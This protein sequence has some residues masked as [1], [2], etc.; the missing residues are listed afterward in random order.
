MAT[1]KLGTFD[2]KSAFEDVDI[3]TFTGTSTPESDALRTIITK[4]AG[5]NPTIISGLESLLTE[6]VILRSFERAILTLVTAK[7]ERAL[8][9]VEAGLQTTINEVKM[10]NAQNSPYMTRQKTSL[11]LYTLQ[12][13]I[14]NLDRWTLPKHAFNH[15]K[16]ALKE[17]LQYARQKSMAFGIT[18]D[19]VRRECFSTDYQQPYDPSL[20]NFEFLDESRL[21]SFINRLHRYEITQN[22]RDLYNFRSYTEPKGASEKT[23]AVETIIKHMEKRF[24]IK[25]M[26]LN[27][28]KQNCNAINK[29]IVCIFGPDNLPAV[30]EIIDSVS[31]YLE[32][33]QHFQTQLGIPPVDHTK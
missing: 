22:P 19:I 33:K 32:A 23:K 6:K 27:Y 7:N 4:I 26:D 20:R 30:V 8:Q 29:E 18:D 10:Y 28:Y 11:Y 13:L 17:K 16:P 2:P 9:T 1:D 31:Q 15:F 3:Q 14:L 21:D 24:Q 25:E 5:N 12:H